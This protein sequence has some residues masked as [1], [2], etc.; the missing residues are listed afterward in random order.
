M[1][2]ERSSPRQH[3]RFPTA[4]R[5]AASLT[6]AGGLSY[7]DAQ[8][9]KHITEIKKG[10]SLCRQA[11]PAWYYSVT[12]AITAAPVIKATKASEDG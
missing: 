11:I 9:T 5:E 1:V 7:C 6:R 12:R 10:F 4:A 3:G 2:A 8:Y